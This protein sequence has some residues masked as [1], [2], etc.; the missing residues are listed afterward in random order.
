MN[1]SGRKEHSG[2]MWLLRVG[3]FD[4]N[5]GVVV[6]DVHPVRTLLA[7]LFPVETLVRR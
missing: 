4:T 5:G 3:T 6:Q 7:T 2:V 1:N